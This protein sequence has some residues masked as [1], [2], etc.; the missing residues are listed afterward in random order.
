MIGR[1]SG[2]SRFNIYKF[3]EVLGLRGMEKV[4]SK[5]DD[6]VVD[7]L[8]Y[9]EPLERFEYRGDKFSCV[10]PITTRAREFCSSWR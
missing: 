4:V 1:T 5:R 3:S 7:A 9:F 10:V 2:A 6:F 8:F